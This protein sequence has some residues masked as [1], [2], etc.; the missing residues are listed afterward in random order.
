MRLTFLLRECQGCG[1]VC[2]PGLRLSPCEVLLHSRAI[3]QVAPRIDNVK[4]TLPTET[5][6]R[7]RDTAV[8]LS[9]CVFPTTS[10]S[11][12][13]VCE[14]PRDGN[15]TRSSGLRWRLVAELARPT[16]QHLS[17][18]VQLGARACPVPALT[19]FGDLHHPADP[20]SKTRC[21]GTRRGR[22]KFAPTN[23]ER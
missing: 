1:S 23:G 19:A 7:P 20:T 21:D 13:D 12:A 8:R 18:V 17:N 10:P 4:P 6:P 2:S 14:Q 11:Q 9:A 16:H 5:A 15:Y 3:E 22:L